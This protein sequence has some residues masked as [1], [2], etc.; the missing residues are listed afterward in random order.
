MSG[1]L[2]QKSRGEAKLPTA[3]E[4]MDGGAYDFRSPRPI[5]KARLDTA[6][7]DL[8]RDDDGRARVRLVS[9]DSE[10]PVTLWLDEATGT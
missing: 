10:T 3:A 2:I 9:P 7:T 5:G 4:P 1:G 8:E 6:L